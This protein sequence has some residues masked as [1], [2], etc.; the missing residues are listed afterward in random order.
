VLTVDPETG[1]LTPNHIPFPGPDFLNTGVYTSDGSNIFLLFG[2]DP[3]QTSTP[4]WFIGIINMQTLT[5]VKGTS[6]SV[7]KYPPP[8]PT[9]SAPS[10]SSNKT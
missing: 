8:P 3:S 9:S 2:Q 5:V 10:R 7:E 6:H 1:A 4:D